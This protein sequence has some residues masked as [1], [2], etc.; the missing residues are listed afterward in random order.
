[1]GSPAANCIT[2]NSYTLEYCDSSFKTHEFTGTVFG[3]QINFKVLKMDSSLFIWIGLLSKEMLGDLCLAMATRFQPMPIS[4]H[5]FGEFTD[6][7]S[8]TFAKKLAKRLG[9]QVF[10]SYNITDNNM[11]P[12]IEKILCEEIKKNPQC[13]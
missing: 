7:V 10:L 2:S 8:P 1:M 11:L 5:F 13:F 12:E 3:S 9:K 4:T 6:I